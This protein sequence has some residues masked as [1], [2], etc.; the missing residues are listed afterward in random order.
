MPA[1]SAE[2]RAHQRANK[3][4]KA[5]EDIK[6]PVPSIVQTSEIAPPPSQSSESTPAPLVSSSPSPHAID[7]E[8]FIDL[9]NLDDILWFCDAAASTYEG[10]HLKHFWDRAFEAGLDRGRAEERDYRDE[11]YIRGKAQGIKEAEAAKV[12]L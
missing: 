5:K 3:L 12:D 1:A 4:S 2:K 9:A 7:F 10:R 11:M 8:M 6:S